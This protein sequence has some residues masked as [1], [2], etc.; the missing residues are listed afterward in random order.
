M[1]NAEA[2]FNN[3]LRPRKPEGSLGRTAQDGHDHPQPWT[4]PLQIS[5]AL[6]LARRG[7]SWNWCIGTGTNK[8]LCEVIW[9]IITKNF[10]DKYSFIVLSELLR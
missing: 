5:Q 1:F 4:C 8:E 10:M 7:Y 6:A 3:F 2:W 9:G